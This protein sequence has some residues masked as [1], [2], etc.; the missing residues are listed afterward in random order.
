MKNILRGTLPLFED[1][2]YLCHL[3]KNKIIKYEEFSINI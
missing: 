2:L 1:K 3:F